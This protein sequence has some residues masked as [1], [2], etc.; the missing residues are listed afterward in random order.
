MKTFEIVKDYKKYR[1]FY[2]STG[3]LVV[4]GKSA[5]QNDALLKKIK[6]SNE[7]FYIMHTAEPGSPFS[8]ILAPIK[9]IK[10]TD[11][12]QTAIFTGCFSRAWR[13]KKKKTQVDIFLSKDIY[14]SNLMKLGTWGV[15]KKLKQKTIT[16]ELILAKQEDTL[17]A[18]PSSTAKKKDILLKIQ[19]GKID[20]TEMLAKIQVEIKTPFKQEEL[21]S[22]LPSGGIKICRK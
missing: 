8:V 3:K 5:Q 6:T 20:K 15:K 22:A 12:E 13:A 17:R 2:T 21:L 7:N 9:S 19:P 16:L 14:K 11:L 1:W 10:P 4:G 18:V